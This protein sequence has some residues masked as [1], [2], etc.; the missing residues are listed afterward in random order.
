MDPVDEFFAH[1]YKRRPVN[2]T[3]TGI[4]EYDGELPDWSASGLATIDAEL[5]DISARLAQSNAE[6]SRVAYENS[7]ELDAELIRGYCAIQASEHDG[8]HG[9][10]GNPA[11]WTGEGVFSVIALMIRDF[12]P[13]GDRV[14]AATKRMNALPDFLLQSRETLGDAPLPAAWTAKALRDCEGAAILFRRGVGCWLES[15]ELPPQ[16]RSTSLAAADRALTAFHDHAAW[17]A[18]RPHAPQTALGCGAAH[19]DLLL[20]A[21]HQCSRSRADLLAEARSSLDAECRKLDEMAAETAGS[22]REVQEAL[23]SDHPAPEEYLATFN[24]EWRACRQKAVEADVVSWPDWP[25]HYEEIPV[26]T[27]DAAPFLYYL[28]YRSPAPFDKRNNYV[29][30]VTPLPASDA[31]PHLRAWNRSVIRLNHVFHHGGVGHHVQ[32]AH[33][34]G[35]SRS[36]VGQIAAV[37]CANRIGMFCGGSMAEGWACYATGLMGEI[38][39]LTPLEVVAEQ[40]SRVRQLARAVV[41][42]AFH[43]GELSFDEA[44]ALFVER[45]GMTMSAAAAEVVKCSM[46]PGTPVMYWLGTRGI[47]ELRDTMRAR[48]GST[49]SLKRFH[50]DLLGCGSIPVA[51]IARMMSERPE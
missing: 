20:R 37:D 38:G 10:R 45:T 11:L 9:P 2:A 8:S 30:V 24:A 36:R 44:A 12:A 22:W 4:H 42:L 43:A 48:A 19:Y 41:D 1:Y 33:A 26:F 28:F 51:M 6:A 7:N 16:E 14:N 25:L 23:A 5:G 21:G 3:F 35:Q 34:Y 40:H 39:A 31:T 32:N 18:A 47:V 15:G 17:L 27:R 29:Y 46:F 50:D 13:L 49:F